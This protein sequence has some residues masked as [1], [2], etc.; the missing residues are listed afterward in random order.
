MDGS[1]P[2][3]IGRLSVTC[4]P[5][6]D[7]KAK[8]TGSPMVVTTSHPSSS[9][10]KTSS[11]PT[12]TVSSAGRLL[13]YDV[14]VHLLVP[15]HPNSPAPLARPRLLASAEH[16]YRAP[17]SFLPW[18]HNGAPTEFLGSVPERAVWQAR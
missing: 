2:E 16:S 8:V 15:R 17:T 11:S 5:P 14:I 9:C 4:A 12:F 1:A 7:S 18:R 3:A 13:R 6:L 10:Q